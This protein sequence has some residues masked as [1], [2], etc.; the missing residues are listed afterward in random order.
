MRHSSDDENQVHEAVR[1]DNAPARVEDLP[2]A[3]EP[4]IDHD[5]CWGIYNGRG[6]FWTPETFRS[7]EAAEKHMVA[8]WGV[9]HIPPEHRIV[10]VTVTVEYNTP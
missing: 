4:R 3:I 1:Q 6:Q 10:S 8:Y 5:D 7:V 9:S 2:D